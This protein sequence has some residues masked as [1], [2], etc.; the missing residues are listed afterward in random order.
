VNYFH[1]N[2][3]YFD[4]HTRKRIFNS[5]RHIAESAR[6]INASE[7]DFLVRLKKLLAV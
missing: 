6:K 5:A 1:D 7:L 3:A 4:D 2:P